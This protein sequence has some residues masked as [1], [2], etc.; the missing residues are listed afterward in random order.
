MKGSYTRLSSAVAHEMP[1]HSYMTFVV[2]KFFI[3]SF[4]LGRYYPVVPTGICR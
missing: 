2:N 1:L 4:I 3:T